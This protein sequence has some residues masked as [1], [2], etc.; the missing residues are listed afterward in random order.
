MLFFIRMK[1]NLKHTSSGLLYCPQF[2]WNNRSNKSIL[3]P[4]RRKGNNLF[5]KDESLS[6]IY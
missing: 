2:C 3:N 6:E 1:N 4:R 5:L